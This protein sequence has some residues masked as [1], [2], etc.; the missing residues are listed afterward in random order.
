MT[1]PHVHI[2]DRSLLRTLADLQ[3]LVGHWN[4][5]HTPKALWLVPAPTCVAGDL[6]ALVEEYVTS[7]KPVVEGLR[8]VRQQ[9]LEF[10]HTAGG[11]PTAIGESIHD[12]FVEAE[13]L[14][15]DPPQDSLVYILDQVSA[16]GQLATA[17]LCAGMMDQGRISVGWSDARDWFVSDE[18][19]GRGPVGV[20]ASTALCLRQIAGLEAADMMVLAMGLAGTADN[21]SV[22]LDE[23][24]TKTAIEVLMR[25]LKVSRCYWWHRPGESAPKPWGDVEVVGV[26]LEVGHNPHQAIEL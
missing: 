9:F 20:D 2:C 12:F 22:S 18:V 15:E 24:N 16:V 14:L 1:G 7:R 3:A 26:P 19:W 5:W 8:Q 4:S 25:C 6:Q 13:W 23:T 11:L 17:V 10:C 21:H